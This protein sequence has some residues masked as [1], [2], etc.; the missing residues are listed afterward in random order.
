[1]KKLH[2]ILLSAALLLAG[3]T[4]DPEITDPAPLPASSGLIIKAACSAVT[5]TD[6]NEGKSTWEAGRPHHGRL[7]RRCLRIHRR[8]S[9]HH[10]HLHQRSGHH[11]LRC[12]Q[13]ADS[14]LPRHDRR[15]HGRRGG[16]GATI[17]FQG[18]EQVNTACAPLVGTP[19]ENNLSDGALHVSF[20]NIF[21]VVELRID[22]GELDSPARS[23]TVEPA[24]EEGFE[25]WL[26]FTGTVD[27]ATLALTPAPDGT[28]R[29]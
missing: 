2:I 9:R 10:D 8:R 14:L 12:V 26:T 20:R 5:R 13:A 6:I 1:M 7:R 23:I 22:A 18:A 28:A 4:R 24:S 29:S 19:L 27:P 16:P 25:G 17:S 15:R 21:S 11:L 3:C